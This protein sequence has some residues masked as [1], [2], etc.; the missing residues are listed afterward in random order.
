M[1]GTLLRIAADEH[2]RHDSPIDSWLT[3]LLFV[4]MIGGGFFALR[5][6]RHL[7]AEQN[8]S[9]AAATR[10][11]IVSGKPA[12]ARILYVDTGPGL[13][14]RDQWN[15]SG[16]R[17]RHG[18]PYIPGGLHVLIGLRLH[19]DD[20]APYNVQ[21]RQQVEPTHLAVLA[22]GATVEVRVDPADASNA[23]IDFT[24]PVV[25]PGP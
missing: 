21:I 11:M 10:E 20:G 19:G 17:F 1:A 16:A 9:M 12:T 7:V 15:Y 2:L 25:P 6:R 22:P 5:W 3:I 23:V 13:S 18:R 4:V 8:A 14:R 24:K